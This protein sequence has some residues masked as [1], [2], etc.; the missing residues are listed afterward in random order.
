M[1]QYSQNQYCTMLI[2][3]YEMLIFLVSNVLMAREG[4]EKSGNKGKET[5]I[6]QDLL[7]AWLQIGE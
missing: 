3:L 6:G 4:N 1:Y 7:K 5:Q 2:R